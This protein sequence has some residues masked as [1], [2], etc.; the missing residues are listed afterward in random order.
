VRRQLYRTSFGLNWFDDFN[1]ACG[2]P[3]QARDTRPVTM[4]ITGAD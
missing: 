2:E 3:L 4:P 1:V